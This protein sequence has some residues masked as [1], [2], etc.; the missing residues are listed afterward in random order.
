LATDSLMFVGR[1]PP[2]AMA[3]VTHALGGGIARHVDDM[4]ALLRAAGVPVVQVQPGP[5]RGLVVTSEHDRGQAI[6]AEGSELTA[7]LAVAGVTHAHVHSLFGY[8]ASLIEE[9]P[10]ALEAAG[11]AYD[12]T[13][14]DFLPRCPRV[15]PVGF[16]GVFCTL[17]TPP[18]CQRCVD[19]LGTEIG[20][21]DVAAW[22]A[23]YG[24]LLR[25]ARRIFAPSADVAHWF[26][27]EFEGI[28]PVLRPHPECAIDR[29]PS[30]PAS[31]RPDGR[32]RVALLGALGRHKGCALL[33]RT[34]TEAVIQG[35][36]LDFVVVGYTDR[37]EQLRSLGNVTITGAYSEKDLLGLLAAQRPDLVWFPAVWPETYSYTLS[38]ALATPLPIVAFDLGAP[39]ERLRALGRGTLLGPELMTKPHLLARALVRPYP[40]GVP[41]V[42][43][44]SYPDP[45]RSYYGFDHE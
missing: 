34:A 25:G 8:P 41:T 7:A 29:P 6:A 38:A 5:R 26:E 10:E 36:P 20:V 39:A 9:W 17:P 13:L 28:D 4:S 23:R 37:D 21:V 31:R 11:L 22:L 43:S 12:F 14:H 18:S 44:V 15:Q 24:R 40:P 42:A 35:V 27:Q 30:W 1:Q 32:V 3:M 45:L 2:A 16:G 19:L 33:E